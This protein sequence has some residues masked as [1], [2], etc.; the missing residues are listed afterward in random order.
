MWRN[1]NSLSDQLDVWIR[2]TLP[3]ALGYARALLRDSATA[4]DVVHDCYARLIKHAARYDLPRDGLKI[5]LRSISNACID[6]RAR[7]RVLLSLDGGP[8]TLTSEIVDRQ[9]PDPPQEAIASELAN[10]IEKALAKLPVGQRAAIHL[11]GLGYTLLEVAELLGTTHG[12]VRL[13]V[14]RARK[15]LE[16]DLSPF[17]FG[18]QS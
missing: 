10:L 17:M 11:S 12:N 8:D 9:S 14:H 2:M 5:L 18:D 15:T 16:V 7:E 4:E 6:Q 3:R 1:F 13:L